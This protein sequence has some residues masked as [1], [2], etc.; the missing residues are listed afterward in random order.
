MPSWILPIHQNFINAFLGSHNSLKL[1]YFTQGKILRYLYFPFIRP[2]KINNL[3]SP[4]PAFKIL[5]R[6]DFLLYK[7][8]NCT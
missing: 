2:H 1:G 6:A 5:M 4:P 8:L 3:V 7:S